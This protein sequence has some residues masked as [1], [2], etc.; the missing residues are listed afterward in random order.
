[1][2]VD[3][4]FSDTSM[5]AIAGALGGV[6]R[7]LTLRHDWREGL[8][9]IIVGSICAIYLGPLVEPMLAPVVGAVA[10]QHDAVGFASFITGLGGISISGFILDLINFRRKQIGGGK[11]GPDTET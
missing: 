6:V 5:A 7:W 8:M 1:M 11:D 10:P 9:A 2:K 3:W 4:M